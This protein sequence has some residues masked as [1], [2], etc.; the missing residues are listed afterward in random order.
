L[1]SIL[2]NILGGFI[3]KVSDHINTEIENAQKYYNDQQQTLKKDWNTNLKKLNRAIVRRIRSLKDMEVELQDTLK[4]AFTQN[5]VESVVFEQ[6]SCAKFEHFWSA[7]GDRLTLLAQDLRD[8][9]K[10]INNALFK[11]R[12]MNHLE[13]KDMALGILMGNNNSPIQDINN[14]NKKSKRSNSSLY[15]DEANEKRFKR[16]GVGFEDGTSGNNNNNNNNNNESNLP[17][18]VKVVTDTTSNANANANANANSDH[19]HN[20]HGNNNRGG[21]AKD[22][23]T[24]DKR[25]FYELNTKYPI[26][27][28]RRLKILLEE[29]HPVYIY[30]TYYIVLFN[31][32]IGL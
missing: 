23:T 10:D 25:N 15:I 29:F 26:D 20:H 32:K 9:V 30:T 19:T 8:A 11:K 2:S 13:Q 18:I 17:S 24:N 16:G 6:T 1:S 12:Q 31:F 21:G 27:N 4:L 5:E 28:Y 22:T 14:S 7:W 3:D